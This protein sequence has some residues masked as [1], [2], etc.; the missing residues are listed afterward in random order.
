MRHRRYYT[1]WAERAAPRLRRH[2]Q[3]TWLRRLDAE[4]ANLR[5]MVG[6]GLAAAQELGDPQAVAQAL[7]G[8][9][10]ARALGGQPGPA[11]RMLG[12]A[13]AARRPPE[14]DHPPGDYAANHSADDSADNRRITAV[15]RQALGEAAFAAEFRH[16]HRLGPQRASSLL[17]GRESPERLRHIITAVS[18]H[19]SRQA[20]AAGTWAADIRWLNL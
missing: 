15:T 17:P 19:C 8:L 11:A 18:D 2:D 6:Q 12:A 5:A 20:R 9:A 1:D 14:A 7:T 16:G 4:A 13:D 3:R 10:G